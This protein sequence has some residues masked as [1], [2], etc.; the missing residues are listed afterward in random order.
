MP[1]ILE[2]H[3]GF[4]TRWV[5][6]AAGEGAPA[7]LVAMMPDT[8]GIVALSY[9]SGQRLTEVHDHETQA[10]TVYFQISR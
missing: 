3:S 5:C 8:A 10:K 2:F 4:V 7:V 1:I 9:E 6:L